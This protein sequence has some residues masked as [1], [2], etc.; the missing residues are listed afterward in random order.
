MASP[1]RRPLGPGGMARSDGWP[2]KCP[3]QTVTLHLGEKGR[4]QDEPWANGKAEQP[5]GREGVLFPVLSFQQGEQRPGHARRI[6]DRGRPKEFP[7]H[8][9]AVL[10]PRSQS[11]MRLT[12][13]LTALCLRITCI[14]FNKSEWLL[15]I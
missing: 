14:F 3:S 4:G 11:R 15:V 12:G 5:R 2:F 10:A 8:R 1:K 6:A 7:S 9:P 13:Q